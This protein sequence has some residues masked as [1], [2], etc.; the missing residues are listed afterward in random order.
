MINVKSFVFNPFMENTYLLY[1]E[2]NECIVIDPGCYEKYE[3]EQVSGFI[4]ETGL[5]VKL[6]INTHCHIDHV[7][8]NQFIKD[9]YGVDLIIHEKEEDYLRSVK[10]YAPSYGISRFQESE[11]DQYIE[12]GEKI[13][14]GK[15]EMEVLFV[16]GHSPGHIALYCPG[17][18]FCIGGDVLFKNSIG[19]TDLPGGN[20]QELLRS[21]KNKMMTLPDETLVYTGHGPSTT[22]GDE[23]KT[24]PF[25]V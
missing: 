1:D 14:F 15:S 20:H 3:E 24:N 13:R 11:A 18:N 8:G 22:I 25:I 5:T 23:K 4:V 12:E 2:T 21:I 17:Q 7:F 16:P 19:R 9:K 10:L 6:L